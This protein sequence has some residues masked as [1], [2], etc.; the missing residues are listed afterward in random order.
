MVANTLAELND[1]YAERHRRETINH[2][3]GLIWVTKEGKVI[4]IEDM[5][6]NHLN[7]TIKML[8]RNKMHSEQQRRESFQEF[9]DSMSE[10]EREEFIK[11]IVL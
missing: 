10:Q 4:A 3:S 5:D 8:E 2:R 1:L 9:I 11:Y 7:N 6:D